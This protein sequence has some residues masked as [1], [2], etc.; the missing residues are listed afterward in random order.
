MQN[1]NKK[2]IVRRVFARAMALDDM[3]Y[4]DDRLKDI[5]R[6]LNQWYSDAELLDILKA[7]ADQLGHSPAQKEIFWVYR[8]LIKQRFG[9]WPYALQKAGLAKSAGRDGVPLEAMKEDRQKLEEAMEAIRRKTEELGRLPTMEEMGE[10]IP[11]LKNRFESW[12]EVLKAAGINRDWD[13]GRTVEMLAPFAEV[14]LKDY[15]KA[16]KNRKNQEDVLFRIEKPDDRTKKQLA[17]VR[18][19]A[20]RLGRAPL[21][22]EIPSGLYGELLQKFGSWRN[23][24]YQ[25]DLEPLGKNETAEIRRIQKER[26]IRK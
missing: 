2:E 8:G 12:A 19:A 23:I 5:V 24:L 1:E 25:I 4:R 10:T 3:E 21:K 9:K 7:A 17:V 22:N 11:L 16:A 14:W 6:G 13:N 18:R 15:G 26:K 20:R